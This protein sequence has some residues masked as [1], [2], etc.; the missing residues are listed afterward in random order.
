M[1]RLSLL[2][3]AIVLLLASA[4]AEPITYNSK[5]KVITFDIASMSTK[6]LKELIQSLDPAY[7]EYPK[8]ETMVFQE[9]SKRGEIVWISTLKSTAAESP[10]NTTAPS[11][12]QNDGTYVPGFQSFMNTFYP[13]VVRIDDDLAEAMME[14]CKTGMLWVDTNE[15][16]IY[17]EYDETKVEINEAFGYLSEIVFTLKSDEFAQNEQ[18]F[19]E[20]I[21]AATKAV[22]PDRPESFYAS[23][24]DSIKYQ[25]TIDSPASSIS[26]YTNFG[27]YQFGLHK[28]SYSTYLRIQLSLYEY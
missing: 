15:R 16:D 1:K 9:L 18:K 11:S 27:V 8:I 7:A 25:Y 4:F 10:E 21:I 22:L 17:G 5:N 3:L 13:E 26:M 2:L 23:I 12:F 19:K 28:T 14:K 20:L 6:D 24:F